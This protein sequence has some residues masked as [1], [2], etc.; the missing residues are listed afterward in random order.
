G[1]DHPNTDPKQGS[2]LP[3]PAPD[4]VFVDRSAARPDAEGKSLA[5]LAQERRAHPADVMCDLAVAD[6]L[7]TQFL[8]NSESPEW[9][10]ANAEAQQN[11]HM[12]VGTGDGGAHADR[13]DRA[14]ASTYHIRPG[15]RGRKI[16]P[17]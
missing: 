17:L 14:E 5:Q 10:E 4:R 7:E 9:I 16:L 6:D 3:P 1:L 15:V 2:T 12:I 8:W 11:P 13:D